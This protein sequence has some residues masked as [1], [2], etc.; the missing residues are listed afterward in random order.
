M[1]SSDS[2]DLRHVAHMFPFFLRVAA[3]AL[4]EHDKNGVSQTF[5]IS[6]LTAAEALAKVERSILEA[7][8]AA[9]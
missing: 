9:L 5:P 7:D 3:L 1:N 2:G 8:E 4:P 6:R